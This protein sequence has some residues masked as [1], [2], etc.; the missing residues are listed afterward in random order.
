MSH[1]PPNPFNEYNDSL[2]S[3]L[4]LKIAKLEKE[5]KRLQVENRFLLRHSDPEPCNRCKRL[6]L[7]GQCCEEPNF[8]TAFYLYHK[9]E[10]YKE[11][12]RLTLNCFYTADKKAPN[13]LIGNI[14]SEL[15]KQLYKLTE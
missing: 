1:E 3:E 13:L 7:A 5:N 4:H 8:D 14:T 9:L 2:I 11:Y 15:Y 12:L 6:V 10:K